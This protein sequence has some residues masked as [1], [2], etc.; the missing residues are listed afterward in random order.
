MGYEMQ[1]NAVA[2]VC[3]VAGVKM[4]ARAPVPE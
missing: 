4:Q 3:V 2:G 1:A